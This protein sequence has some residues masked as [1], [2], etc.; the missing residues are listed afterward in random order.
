VFKLSGL[1][2]PHGWNVVAW[3]LAIVTLGVLIALVV[4]QWADERN[5]D[6]R[7]REALA[8]IKDEMASH[9]IQSV[10]WRVVEPCIVALAA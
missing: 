6:H 7:T 1:K 4:Q 9:Y 5:T 3:D 2:P 8:G 10:E